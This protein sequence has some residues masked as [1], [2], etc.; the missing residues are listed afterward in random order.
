MSAS[1][2]EELPKSFCSLAWRYAQVDL[3][4]GKVKAC[5]KTPFHRVAETDLSTLGTGAL[6]NNPDFQ[7]RRRAMLDGAYP[8][9]CKSCW[10]HEN[11]GVPSY[12]QTAGANPIFAT[13]SSAADALAEIR[14]AKPTHLELIL[15]TTCDLKCVYC[16]PDFSSAWEAEV[17]HHGLLPGQSATW[18]TARGSKEFV[19]AFWRWFD[20]VVPTL[21]YVQFNGGEPLIQPQFHRALDRLLAAMPNGM[22]VGMISN[23]NTPPDAF[24]RFMAR[25][26]EL[27]DRF[28]FRVAV[29][30]EAVGARAEYIRFGLSWARFADN[31]ERLTVALYPRPVHLAPTLSALN[32]GAFTEYIAHI[33]QLA[34][35]TGAQFHWRPSIVHEPAHLSPLTLG[36]DATV[37]LAEAAEEAMRGGWTELRDWLD[38]VAA[39]YLADDA[40][41]SGIPQIAPE[42]LAALDERRSTSVAQVFPELSECIDDAR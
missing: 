23:L 4:R 10:D 38:A 19:E 31:L 3:Q 2:P 6:F 9:A 1:S 27:L 26:P 36:K 24:K 39:S 16:D 41:P 25:L 30:Q 8:S 11:A 34:E 14:A 22:Q 37:W 15:A 20:E 40:K 13:P 32:I 28:E 5:C 42:F 35:R 12:R 29:S 33:G 17:R 7:A 18:D 21:R